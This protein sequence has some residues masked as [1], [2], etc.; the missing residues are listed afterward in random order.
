MRG[1][2]H[3]NLRFGLQS[4]EAQNTYAFVHVRQMTM[5]NEHR[6]HTSPP[7]SLRVESIH[8]CVCVCTRTRVRRSGARVHECVHLARLGWRHTPFL[9][10]IAGFDHLRLRVSSRII[11]GVF[12][13]DPPW[14]PIWVEIRRWL[15]YFVDTR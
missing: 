5:C 7:V 1:S 3:V 9:I 8:E 10:Q 15:V 14:R 4:V 6:T 12:V 13:I 11:V 2:E